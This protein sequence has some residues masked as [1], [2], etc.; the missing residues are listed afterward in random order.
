MASEGR[1]AAFAGRLERE[2]EKAQRAEFANAAPT[3]HPKA[4]LLGGQPGSGKS[5]LASAALREFSGHGGAVLIDADRMRERNP[6]YRD[7]LKFDPQNA[8]DRTHAIAGAWAI[9]MTAEAIASKRNVVV[10]G[11]MRN[12]ENIKALAERLK[13]NG[14][15]VHVRVL[16]VR[17]EVSMARS[18]L[19]FEAQAAQNGHGRFVHKEQHDA[20]YQGI[21]ATLR[22]LEQEKLADSVKVYSESRQEIYSNVMQRGQWH[23]APAASRALEQERTR[24]QSLQERKELARTW[25]EIAGM[26]EA[27]ERR[28]GGQVVTDAG[29]VLERHREALMQVQQAERV[30]AER[31]KVADAFRNEKPARAI[32]LHPELA[33][34]YAYVRATE[35]KAEADGLSAHQRAVVRARVLENVATRLEQGDMPRVQLRDAAQATAERQHD[36]DR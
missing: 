18:R 14:Y 32:A 8:A 22:M 24:V 23:S 31:A 25:G 35:A 13:A 10:D 1:S 19:R 27:R 11:T 12:P 20:A 29:T 17:E 2:Y 7:L 9:R 3:D 5:G 6:E 28:A 4:I 33:G 26:V 16:A 15:E 34:A 30:A 36:R 21:P